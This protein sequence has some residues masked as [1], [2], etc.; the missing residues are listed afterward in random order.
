MKYST[1]FV[2]DIYIYIYIY[3]IHNSIE[4]SPY[5]FVRGMFENTRK[6][7]KLARF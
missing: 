4:I 5:D 7:E 6:N 2:Y 1:I 3:I